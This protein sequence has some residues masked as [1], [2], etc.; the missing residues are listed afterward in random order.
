MITTNET[1]PGLAQTE[2]ETRAARA[3]AEARAAAQQVQARQFIQEHGA[4][5]LSGHMVRAAEVNR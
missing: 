4:E 1:A 5:A 3:A 2:A